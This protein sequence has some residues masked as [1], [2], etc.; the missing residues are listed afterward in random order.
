MGQMNA[1]SIENQERIGAQ[2]GD[3][4]VMEEMQVHSLIC[5]AAELCSN[6]PEL[7]I[8]FIRE[9]HSKTH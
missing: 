7:F 6:D 3:D 4:A 1:L 5:E 8:L 9:M 2:E